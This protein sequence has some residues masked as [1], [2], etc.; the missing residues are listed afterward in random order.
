MG[1][2]GPAQGRGPVG[3]AC[4][5][6]ATRGSYVMPAAA[7]L[8]CLGVDG[9]GWASFA[10]HWEDLAP[11]AYAAER[12][13]R[14][15]RRYGHFSLSRTGEITSLPHLAFVQPEQSNPL[16]VDVSRNFE[17]LT[18]AFRSEPL[19][20]AL[21][22][23]LGEVATSLADPDQ[24]SVKVH[25][26]R[27]TAEADDAGDPTPEGRHH[28]GVALVTSL[29]IGRENAVGGESTVYGLDGAELMSTTLSEP[30]TLLLGDDRA[31]LHGVSPIRPLDAARPARRDVLV[32]TLTPG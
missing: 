8:R 5:A 9:E 20:T 30:G 26:F 3:D 4:R 11:D 21:I 13:T 28:D 27:V 10:A 23:A 22:R 24:W 1:D 7:L 19:L 25:P 6:L 29:L 15:L 18:A 17:P 12:G 32:T 2:R 14:R 16:Y 31:T